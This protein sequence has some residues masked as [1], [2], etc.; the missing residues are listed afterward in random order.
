[1]LMLARIVRL[2]ATVVAGVIVAG[3]L[4]HVLGANGSNALVSALYDVDRW[5]VGPFRGLFQ[6]DDAKA[7]IALNWGI[8]AAVYFAVGV[9]VSR[10]LAR[11][12]LLRR[13]PVARRRGVLT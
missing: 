12:A 7:E 9:L 4:C 11:A 8:A 2:A 6:L 5:L 3:I 1:M 13:R 10:L